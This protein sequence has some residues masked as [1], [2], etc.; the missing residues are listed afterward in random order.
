MEAR[1][2]GKMKS[3]YRIALTILLM[4]VMLVSLVASCRSSAAGKNNTTAATPIAITLFDHG[5]TEL[6]QPG[7]E[8]F[9][10][11]A[12]AMATVIQSARPEVA[13][14][15]QPDVEADRI[16]KEQRAVEVAYQAPGVQVGEH[17]TYTT[18]LI[19][20]DQAFAPQLTELFLGRDLAY[21][22]MVPARASLAALYQA[23]GVAT[24]IP[25][26]QPAVPTK[27]P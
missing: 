23:T 4:V 16:K 25:G 6:L 7:S 8:R 2:G 13:A 26:P 15:A 5:K 27:A 22:R 17:G 3:R 9:K 1:K 10:Q 20:L 14:M 24:P 19:Q 12:A 18:V 21:Q 11:I